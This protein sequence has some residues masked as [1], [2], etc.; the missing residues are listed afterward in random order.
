MPSLTENRKSLPVLDESGKAKR[1]TAS[2]LWR[3]LEE[4]VRGGPERADVAAEFP[5]GAAHPPDEGMSRRSFGQLLGAS[6]ALAGLAA[7]VRR[8]HEQLLPYTRTP[9]GVV[10]GR[11][12]HYASSSTLGGY[13]TGLLVTSHT[14]RP[15]KIEGNPEHPASLGAT[16]LLEQA[17]VLGLYDPD[18]PATVKHHGQDK[19]YRG[20]L[21]AQAEHAAELEAKKG[22]GLYFL[23]EPSASPA[24]AGLRARIQDKFKGAK[25]FSYSSLASDA[26][27]E[28]SKIAFGQ[29]LEARY[30][31]SKAKVIALLDSDLLNEPGT[32]AHQRAFAD[33]RVGEELNRLYAIETSMTPSG[34]SADHRLP[35]KPSELPRIAI[36]L[37]GRVARLKGGAD[38]GHFATLNPTLPPNQ[39]KF[40]DALAKDLVKNADESLVVAGARASLAVQLACQAINL[41]LGSEGK[42]VHFQKPLL[43]DPENGP[44]KLAELAADIKAGKVH[45]LYVTAW[46]PAYTAPADLNFGDLLASV[47]NSVYLGAYEDETTPKA[48]WYIPAAHELETWGDG[49]SQDGTITFQQPTIEPM[50][51]GV[52]QLELLA[53]LL[54]EADK[55]SYGLLRAH[56]ESKAGGALTNAQ[57]EKAVSDGFIPAKA[58]SVTVSAKWDAIAA[59]LS[60]A[61]A[62]PAIDGIEVTFMADLKVHDGRFTNNAWLQELPDPITR[63]TWDNAVLLSPSTAKRLGVDYRPDDQGHSSEGQKPVVDV[64]V[65]GRSIRAT[66]FVQP[67]QAQETA[68]LLLGWGRTGASEKLCKGAGYNAGALRTTANFWSAGPVTI[69]PTGLRADLSVTQEHFSMEGRNIALTTTLAELKTGSGGAKQIEESKGALPSLHEKVNYPGFAWAMAI[70]LS[71]CTGCSACVIACQSEN[72]IPIVGKEQI[73]KSREMQWLRIDRYYEGDAE[74]P[75]TIS[76][77]LMCVHCE[78]APCEYVCPVN[79]TVHSDEG[80]NE[81]VYNR[82]VGTRYCSNNCP[83]KVR[84][85]NFF[86]YTTNYT[87]VEKMVM[88]PDVTVRARGV[89]EKCTYCVQRIERARIDTRVAGTQIKDGDI[90]TACEQACATKA[91]TFGSLHDPESRVSKLHKDERR[92]DLLHELGTRPRTAYLA[93]LKNPNPELA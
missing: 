44:A 25:F 65:G 20:F 3:S 38:L 79:A 52:S 71:R 45:T 55:G 60:K 26:A 67:G 92:Y 30:D 64:A 74:N 68:T 61:A 47:K 66:V 22:E 85:F 17:S 40:L 50:R 35:A 15:T 48:A 46:N 12:Q 5:R 59:E 49:R 58:E 10:P 57:W 18:R 62:V 90:V 42:T 14:G 34:S 83:Y 87:D 7:C 82:C 2:S 19:S 28:S 80:L 72:N 53:A 6:A 9:E 29:H 84:R 41:G 76:Q 70:D 63:M 13:A 89:M 56:H 32:L 24:L 1:N 11:A 4:R 31:L 27:S 77:P 88:N 73:A 86:S 69:A 16:G 8:P 81:M 23:M 93:K 54:G 37:L 33:G 75:S 36:G 39:M 21:T 78:M 91:I 51:N 43:N